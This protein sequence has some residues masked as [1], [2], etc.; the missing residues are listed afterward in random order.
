LFD[1]CCSRFAERTIDFDM[2]ADVEDLA[3]RDSQWAALVDA[4]RVFEAGDPPPDKRAHS[5]PEDCWSDLDTGDTRRRSFANLEDD[6]VGAPHVAAVPIGHF[7]V[8]HVANQVH[9][10]HP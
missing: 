6:A 2:V 5:V 9:I 7:L 4:Q 3:K 10:S 1:R 8:E